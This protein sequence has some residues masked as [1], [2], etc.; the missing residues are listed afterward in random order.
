V[1]LISGLGIRCKTFFTAFYVKKAIWIVAYS[2]C[3]CNCTS[4]IWKCKKV[5]HIKI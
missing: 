4:K 3:A 2:F 5:K 1:Q